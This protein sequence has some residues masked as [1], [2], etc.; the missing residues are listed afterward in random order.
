MKEMERMR[1]S[2]L[3]LLAQI[4]ASSKLGL[5]VDPEIAEFNAIHRKALKLAIKKEFVNISLGR[6]VTLTQRGIAYLK[7]GLPDVYDEMDKLT[8]ENTE[9]EVIQKFWQSDFEDSKVAKE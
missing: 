4:F 7:A 1:K 6:D 8:P 3:T 9:L 2:L 5:S